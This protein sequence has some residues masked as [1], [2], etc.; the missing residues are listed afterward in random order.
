MAYGTKNYMVHY[1]VIL[2]IIIGIW[3]II[4][5]LRHEHYG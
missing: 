1:Y 3:I 5:K 2:G 4:G